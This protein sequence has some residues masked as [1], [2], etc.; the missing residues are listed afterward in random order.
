MPGAWE[1]MKIETAFV[2]LVGRKTGLFFFLQF[3]ASAG[4][5]LSSR[6]S[7]IDGIC[8]SVHSVCHLPLRLQCLTE[9][10]AYFYRCIHSTGT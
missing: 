5:A 6:D 1:R 8:V 9:S 3:L 2:Y 4:L 7:P 10:L